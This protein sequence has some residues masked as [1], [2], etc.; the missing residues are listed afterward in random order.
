MLIEVFHGLKS[1]RKSLKKENLVETKEILSDTILNVNEVLKILGVPKEEIIAK[2]PKKYKKT[3]DATRR[4]KKWQ[5][6]VVIG[7]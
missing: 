7:N 1:A 3:S 5:K 2:K 4:L 6:S